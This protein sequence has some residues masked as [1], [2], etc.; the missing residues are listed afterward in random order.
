MHIANNYDYYFIIHLRFACN[1]N[2]K[3]TINVHVNVWNENIKMFIV[4]STE[5]HYYCLYIE[6]SCS[7]INLF[8]L[9]FKCRCFTV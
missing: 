7:D 3:I 8:V 2:I 5:N 4:I 6:G 9:N 1:E